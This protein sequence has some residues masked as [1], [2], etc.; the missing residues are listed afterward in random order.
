[1]LSASPKLT[2]ATA[3]CGD[4][5]RVRH[6][7]PDCPHCVRLHELGFHDRTV[8]KKIADGAAIICLLMGTR[9]ALGRELGEH[10]EVERLTA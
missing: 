5:L 3:K 6:I 1:M 2:L 4:R 10:V 9:V 7:C 8:L